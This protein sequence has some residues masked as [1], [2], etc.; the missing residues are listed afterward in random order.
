M[1]VRASSGPS[2][3]NRNARASTTLCSPFAGSRNR[4]S[5]V[6]IL[7]RCSAGSGS[8]STI[9]TPGCIRSG[10]F[11]SASRKDTSCGLINATGLDMS[12]GK[13]PTM[14]GVLCDVSD[15]RASAM[16]L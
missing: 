4:C 6:A 13:A 16:L 8:V 11:G 15:V 10:H 5:A 1:M 12:N 14:I 3:A 2:A 7:A 9:R